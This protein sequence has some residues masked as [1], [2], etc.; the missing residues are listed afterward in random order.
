LVYH[1]KLVDALKYIK[2][3]S[4]L[5]EMLEIHA[6]YGYGVRKTQLSNPQKPELVVRPTDKP[7]V[8]ESRQ[9]DF[10]HVTNGTTWKTPVKQPVSQSHAVYSGTPSHD[11]IYKFLKENGLLD[12]AG[13]FVRPEVRI[14]ITGLSLSTDDCVPVLLTFTPILEATDQAY[15]INA[16]KARD[17]AGLLTFISDTGMPTSPRHLNSNQWRKDVDGKDVKPILTTKEVHAM[18]LQRAFN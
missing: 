5:K 10:V 14:G 11:A 3:Y 13:K 15:K 18:F 9:F 2:E 12:E 17:Y 4:E 1:T 16:E 6:H 8:E 7:G